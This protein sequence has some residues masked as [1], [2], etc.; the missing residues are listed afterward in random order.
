MNPQEYRNLHPRCNWCEYKK[1]D[2]VDFHC[3]YNCIVKDRYIPDGDIF[4]RW[5]GMFCKVYKPK[6]I[7]FDI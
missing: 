5:R 7:D 2:H 3:W 1:F 4:R 6:E